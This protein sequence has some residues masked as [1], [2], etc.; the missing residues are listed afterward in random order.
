MSDSG[1]NNAP[2]NLVRRHRSARLANRPVLFNVGNT[3]ERILAGQD[4]A[5]EILDELLGVAEIH[6]GIHPISSGNELLG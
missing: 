4:V 5:M 2:N 3:P 6:G 1:T